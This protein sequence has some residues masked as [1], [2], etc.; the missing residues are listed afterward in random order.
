MKRPIN[1]IDW[2]F[3]QTESPSRLAHVAGLMLFKLPK[4]YRKNF[5][6]EFMHGLEDWG[7]A[8]PPF[9]LKLSDGRIELPHWVDDESFDI[10]NHVRLVALPK[11]GSLGQL[12]DLVARIHSQQL[13]RSQPL[14]ECY[15][16]EG[17]KDRHVAIYF[18]FHHAMADGMVGM[19]Y[20]LAPLS[21]SATKIARSAMWQPDPAET[22]GN[23]KPTGLFG[24]IGKASAN[25]LAQ[26]K[27]LPE[28]TAAIAGGALSALN[29][30]GQ[31][32]PA[33]FT[34]PHTPMNRAITPRRRF[35]VQKIALSRVK[36][37]GKNSNCTVN[38]VVLALCGS[39]LKRYLEEKEQLPD[40][41]LVAWVPV[42]LRDKDAKGAGNQVG[43]AICSLATLVT[44]PLERLKETSRSSHASIQE[45]RGRTRQ[46]ADNYNLLLGGLELLSQE[47]G[48]AG[49]IVHPANVVVSNVRGSSRPQ[50]LNGARLVGLF[51]VSM[52]TDGQAL[53]ITVTSQDDSLDFGL[54]SCPDAIPEVNLIASYLTDALDELEASI[55]RAATAARKSRTQKKAASTSAAVDNLGGLVTALR[56]VKAAALDQAVA[57]EKLS[58]KAADGLRQ[59]LEQLESAT[60]AVLGTAASSGAGKREGLDGPDPAL[61]K[62]QAP[63]WN[64]LMDRYFRLAIDGWEHIPEQPCLLIGVHS[65][66]PLTMD[67]WTVALA[68]WRHFGESRFL[69]GTAH[70]VLMNARGIG[71]Y[72]RRLGVI[73]PTKENL[74]AAFAKGDSV[75]LWPGGE[76]DAYRSWS[77]RDKAVLGGRKGFIRLAM[78][79][80]VPIVPVA[81]VGGHDT[82]FVLS[83]GRGIAKALGLKKRMRSDVAPITFSVPFGVTLHLTPFQHIPLPAKIRTEFLQPIQLDS[84]PA[85]LDDQAYVD[86]MYEMIERALQAGMDKLAKRRKFPLLG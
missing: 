77:K 44:D 65:G 46:T 70:D 85:R 37:V 30:S 81:T 15:L 35:A 32:S 71:R 27:T 14:W 18:K 64:V 3:L 47:L 82:L 76:V 80:G 63:I 16:I 33:P 55:K 53:N 54:L 42:S 31:A 67:A 23:G 59:S 72:F 39:A 51:P 60:Q 36:A 41:S 34:A 62:A 38:D 61:M 29:L 48:L 83:E 49:R 12:M 19:E 28:L 45:I 20:L 11:P 24:L 56:G 69:H 73:S 2:A 68:W 84:D 6:R 66:G 52:L 4:N 17:L 5:F 25:V 40:D 7:I 10:D 22:A 50:Y 58:K 26:V 57:G 43:I 79:E 74:A 78:R 1:P 9:N 86:E 8:T 13:S 21:G 75:I